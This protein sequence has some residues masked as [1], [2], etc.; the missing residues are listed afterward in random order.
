MLIIEDLNLDRPM[1][2]KVA[3]SFAYDVL[4]V[5]EKQ[6]PNSSG[7]RTQLGKAAS[8]DDMVYKH[9]SYVVY[10]PYKVYKPDDIPLKYY[11]K[12]GEDFAPEAA[13]DD[14]LA[15]VN[16]AY[17][18]SATAQTSYVLGYELALE[19]AVY[20][21]ALAAME[22]DT[23]KYVHDRLVSLLPMIL[24]YKIKNSNRFGNV[25]NVLKYLSESDQM[26]FIFNINKLR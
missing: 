10:E 13:T 25:D 2:V 19:S 12:G 8:Y 4:P 1:A 23:G 15:A 22:K 14:E 9:Y 17:A 11:L 26:R 6:Y 18:C 5:F 24:D 21:S 16:A 7:P 20:A 3:L